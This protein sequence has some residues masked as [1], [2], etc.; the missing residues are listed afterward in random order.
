MPGIRRWLPGGWPIVS[1]VACGKAD[2]YVIPAQRVS[3]P[4]APRASVPTVACASLHG[5]DLH[6]VCER[7]IAMRHGSHC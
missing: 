5:L 3:M 4:W 7:G 2:A 1:A 6:M